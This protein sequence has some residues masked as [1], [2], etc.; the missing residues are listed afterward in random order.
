MADAIDARPSIAGAT[1][2]AWAAG[3]LVVG[4]VVAV[5]P[6]GFA[7]FGPLRWTVVVLGGLLLVLSTLRGR[8]LVDRVTA[9][10]WVVLLG[11]LGLAAV[12]GIDPVHVWWGTPER[13][14]GWLSWLLLA[15]VFLAGQQLRSAADLRLLSRSAV[16]AT[17]A[18]GAWSAFELVG[19]APVDVA[20]ADDRVGGPYGQPAYL[21]AAAVLLVPTAMGVAFD[22]GE[23]RAWRW[24]ATASAVSGGLAV[25]ASQTRAAGVAA[26]VVGVAVVAVRRP[27]IGRGVVV[28]VGVVV[29]AV[30][31]VG[32][33]RE[34]SMSLA[35]V[36]AA[37]RLDEWRIAVATIVD[38]PWTG[39]GPEGY[40][41]AVTTHVDEAYE[42]EHGRDVLP[43]RA[44]SSFLDV[45]AVGGLP[46]AV[47]FAT[48][49]GLVLVATVRRMSCAGVVGAGLAAGAFAHVVQGLFLFPLLEVD[50]LF[51]MVAGV[52]VAGGASD[53][54]EF[55]TRSWAMGPVAAAL[56]VV[57]FL[58][59]RDVTADRDLAAA[60]DALDAGDQRAALEAADRATDRRPDS[61]RAWFVAS[62]VA[63]RGDTILDV[64]AALDRIGAGLERSPLD[65]A[66][67]AEE[68]R[69]LLDRAARSGSDTDLEAATVAAEALVTDD[70]NHAEHHLRLGVILALADRLDEAEV[71]LRRAADL[72]PDASAPLVDLARVA[73]RRGD[74]ATARAL[75]DDAERVDAE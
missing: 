68:V 12:R 73:V 69:L 38:D 24:A 74:L 50:P 4:S 6:G 34:R 37:G 48:L 17:G 28:A 56:V 42:R 16:M 13:R 25:L 7:P 65:P 19:L 75:L 72:A 49:V 63:S 3:A 43:D 47:A 61:I 33:L 14:L 32:P 36:G 20:F 44:H 59:V 70:P 5:D 9:M 21:G 22:R 51:W 1:V 23:R 18:L 62:R 26:V 40:R 57:G 27:T 58:G 29:L 39:A 67:R 60:V 45:A 10:A 8:I 71:A 15:L 46:A 35:D 52:L 54:W 53:R 66:L 2:G 11:W 41:I 30:M 31:V 55:E 64:D